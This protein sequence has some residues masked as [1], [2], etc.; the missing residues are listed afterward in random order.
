MGTCGGAAVAKSVLY[1][2]DDTDQRG[3]LYAF[4][5][6]HVDAQLRLGRGTGR[7]YVTRNNDG[8]PAIWM[9]TVTASHVYFDSDLLNPR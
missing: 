7:I 8:A 1:V 3:G 6:S 2:T 5:K 9:L 4:S